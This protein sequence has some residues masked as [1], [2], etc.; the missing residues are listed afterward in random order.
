MELCLDT[1]GKKKLRYIDYFMHRVN[2]LQHY[3]IIPVVVLDG[4]NMPCK[5]ATGDERHRQV[6]FSFIISYLVHSPL[7]LMN[8][9]HLT[10]RLDFILIFRKRKANFDAAMVKLKEGN[11]GAAT[12]LFQVLTSYFNGLGLL[13]V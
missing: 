5:A 11:V 12:E 3:E 2:L 13:V 9:F 7:L 8:F 6:F 10:K 1:D 4:G